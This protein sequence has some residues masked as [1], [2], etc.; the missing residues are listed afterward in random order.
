LNNFLKFLVIAA[1]ITACETNSYD[2]GSEAP[3][4]RG[5]TH[6]WGAALV[7]TE[8]P[9]CA[10]AGHGIRVCAIDQTHT[11]PVDIDPLGHIVANWT[12]YRTATA[13]RDG[14]DTGYCSREGCD[15]KDV[16]H[17]NGE[18]ATGTPGLAF[19]LINGGTEYRVRKGTAITTGSIY[20]P[21][22]HRA[23]V[24]SDYLPVT[25][26]GASAFSGTAI[27]GVHIPEGIRSFGNGA[28]S[29]C[30]SLTSVT[31]PASLTS[32]GD[33]AFSYCDGLL[34]VTFAANG[35]LEI[36]GR[37][38]FSRCTKLAS[39]TITNS[40]TEIGYDAINGCSLLR[41][42][43]FEEGSRLKKIARAPF[44]NCTSLTRITIPAS[45]TEIGS[46]AFYRSGLTAVTFEE[47]SQLEIIGEMAFEQ[48]KITA[49]TIPASV[50]EINGSA[51]YSCTSLRSVIF[52]EGIQ[53][54]SMS[55]FGY[56]KI[57]SITIPASV[58]NSLYGVFDGC[59][60]LANINVEANNPSY[61]SRRGVLYSKDKTI[62][63]AWPTANGDITIPAGVTAIGY[64][65]FTDCWELTGVTIPEGVKS[66]GGGAFMGCY[67][68]NEIT[69]PASVTS[70]GRYAFAT[71]RSPQ[72]IYVKGHASEEEADAAW[73]ANWR[74][75]WS[76]YGDGATIKYWNGTS[77]E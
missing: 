49:I 74:A 23:D 61:T 11:E 66:I 21:V 53:T 12:P 4:G 24:D 62:L 35:R 75:H 52:E 5:H 30:N 29:N 56:S 18:Y 58:T 20:I 37:S 38:M 36:F 25:E 77:Y 15:N 60:S 22:M 44:M 27:T 43:I 51:F 8:P 50:T 59:A 6:L 14:E 34:T 13:T 26:I 32:A 41:T 31:I 67:H 65:A 72:T 10:R 33:S 57:T 70:I 54:K 73:G 1:L 39:V 76:E 19:E 40:V 7:I 45:V 46:Q 48:S 47:G 9:T 69:I 55:S 64:D 16:L 17:F 2:D 42:V 63:V 28:F 71:W 68:I 3:A